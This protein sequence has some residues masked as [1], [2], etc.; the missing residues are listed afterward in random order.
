M[1]K[2]IKMCFSEE[3][4]QDPTDKKGVANKIKQQAKEK[5]E[6][7]RKNCEDNKIESKK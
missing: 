6:Q 1:S 2:S 7:Y 4:R 3:T 5:E